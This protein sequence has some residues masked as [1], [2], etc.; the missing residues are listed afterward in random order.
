MSGVNRLRSKRRGKAYRLDI[1]AE[2]Y[3]RLTAY[4]NSGKW[5]NSVED[6][7]TVTKISDDRLAKIS[8]YFKFPEWVVAQQNEEK[9]I[10]KG[11]SFFRI[12]K[13]EI[14]YQTFGSCR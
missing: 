13:A 5:I 6:F 4:R 3:D 14:T 2:E 9:T 12:S 10:N 7:K 1:T 8:P 11:V